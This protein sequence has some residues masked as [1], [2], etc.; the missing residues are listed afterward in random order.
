MT[1]ELKSNEDKRPRIRKSELVA[2]SDS[3][4]LKSIKN[5]KATITLKLQQKRI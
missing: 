4:T 2:S 5:G 1:T 3:Q